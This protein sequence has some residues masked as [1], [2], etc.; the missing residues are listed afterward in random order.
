MYRRVVDND[1]C[2]SASWS[3]VIALSSELAGSPEEDK[4]EKREPI[5]T[6]PFVEKAI[7]LASSLCWRWNELAG[8]L[9]AIAG[10]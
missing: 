9:I 2:F 6:L 1:P 3:L 8:R 7:I 4:G 5:R 10:N